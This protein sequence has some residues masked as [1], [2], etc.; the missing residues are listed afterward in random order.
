MLVIDQR[1]S[2][3]SLS[4]LKQLG[5]SRMRRGQRFRREHLPQQKRAPAQLVLL[6]Q[7]FPN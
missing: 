2:M 1:L 6:H 3:I 7:P 5:K 4:G